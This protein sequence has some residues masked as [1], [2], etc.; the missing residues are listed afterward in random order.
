MITASKQLNMNL[1]LTAIGRGILILLTVFVFYLSY[2]G[3]LK[4]QYLN[5][6][7]QGRDSSVTKRWS[8]HFQETTIGQYHPDFHALYS[9]QN[10]QPASGE[11]MRV[12]VTSTLFLGV[13]LWK[14]GELYFNPELSGGRGVGGT[15]GVAG[16]PNGETYRIGDPEPVVAPARIF[17]R[18]IISL[19]DPLL[20]RVK[21]NHESVSELNNDGQNQIREYIPTR[22]LVIT[23]GKFSI[24]DIFDNN[25]YSHD[26]R[27]Q[28][29]NWS[30]MSAGAWDYPADTKGYT[31]GG[32]GE[33]IFPGWS[34][35]AGFTM[36][37][38]FAN[39]PVFDKNIGK[40]NAVSLEFD[41]NY[42]CFDKP[43][44][45]R[46]IGYYNHAKM[47]NYNLAT[48]DTTFHLDITETRA[49]G[50]SKL[51]FV[52]NAEQ[53]IND[54]AGVFARLSYNDGKNETWTFTEIDR[55]IS[56][57]VL[58]QG[59]TWKRLQDKL[60]IAVVFNGISDDHK[61][62]L[63]AG[64]YG[65]IIGDGRLNYG[66]E[67]ILEAF[68]DFRWKEWLFISP[69]YQFVLNP[70]YNKDRGPVHLFALRVHA[71]M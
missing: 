31:W 16:F 46:I 34:A 36:M 50:R 9:G 1:A 17:Y 13:R 11:P 54:H 45:I 55:S 59:V 33:I 49:Y 58:V 70:A 69:D 20:Y 43:G 19:N 23:V 6:S 12:S 28:F 65:F 21:K 64:G 15:V 66:Y 10:S 68:Y 56:A 4:A 53:E 44:V 2:P 41:R 39:G 71:E 22:R 24:T 18:Q 29:L 26:A 40:A 51:G 30:L 38:T 57:G 25:S 52:I 8:V 3:Q 7:L 27:T 37:P 47:G 48:Y 60:G 35:K 14:G 67:S 42:K 32:V 5:T 61:N 62:Y 63:A